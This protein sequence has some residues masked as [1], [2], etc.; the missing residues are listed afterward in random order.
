MS[1]QTSPDTNETEIVIKRKTV[2]FTLDLTPEQHFFVKKF[3]LDAGIQASTM[4]RALLYLLEMDE[5]LANRVI[6]EIFAE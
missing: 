3:A 2:R 6:D 1:P 5:D 4:I